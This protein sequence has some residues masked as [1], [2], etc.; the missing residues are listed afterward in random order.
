[1]NQQNNSQQTHSQQSDTVNAGQL[2]YQLTK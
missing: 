2:Y 1:M